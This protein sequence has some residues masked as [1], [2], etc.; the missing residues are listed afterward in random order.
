ME[1]SQKRSIALAIT[2]A[3]ALVIALV[4]ALGIA[5]VPVGPRLPAKAVD[6]RVPRPVIACHCPGIPIAR[7]PFPAPL[8]AF[9][10][11]GWARLGQSSG[12][13]EHAGGTRDER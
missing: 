7:S 2:L 10:G 9:C 12:R 8:E 11:L 13:P 4:I 3:I 1:E 6:R 5:S